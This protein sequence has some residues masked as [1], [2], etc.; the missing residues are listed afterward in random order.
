M[1]EYITSCAEE[2]NQEELQPIIQSVQLQAQGKIPWVSSLIQNPNVLHEE[3]PK[4]TANDSTAFNLKD[5][6]PAQLDDLVVG[7][8]YYF[9]RANKCPNYS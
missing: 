2:T 1:N 4:P 7:R 8:V 9:V 3:H 6:Q 5:I